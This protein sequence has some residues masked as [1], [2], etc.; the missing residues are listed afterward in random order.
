MNNLNNLI[1]FIETQQLISNLTFTLISESEST[2]VQLRWNPSE[3]YSKWSYKEIY[4]SEW[5]DTTSCELE[6][7]IDRYQINFNMF[8]S[9]FEHLLLQNI[10]DHYLIL[11]EIIQSP[12][13]T[14]PT[15]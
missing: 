13:A 15:T 6:K 8:S 10:S 7:I 1:A 9:D 4:S 11:A 3:K 5:I 14:T 2:G 12:T